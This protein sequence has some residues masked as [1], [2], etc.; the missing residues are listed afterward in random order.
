[1]QESIDDIKKL[2]DLGR[3][4]EAHAK[5]ESLLRISEDLRLKQLY[6]LALSKSGV[7]EE[8]LIF[9]EGVY[10]RFPDDPESAGIMGSICKELFKKNQSNPFA[11]R[12]RDTYLKNFLATQNY[13]T[14]INAASMSAMAGQLGKSREIATQVISLIEGKETDFWALATLGEAHMLTKNKPKALEYFVQ[15]RKEAGKDWGKISSVHNQLWLLNHFLPVPNEVMKL[16]NPP[17]V[18]AFIG[19]MIDHPG[20]KEPRFPAAIEKEVKEEITHAIRSLNVHIGYCSLACGGDI[21]FA[22]AMAEQGGEVNIF[23]PF[24]KTDF[25]EVSVAFAGTTWVDRFQALL[26]RFPVTYMS[27]EHYD[28]LDDIF[29]FQTKIIFGAASLRS[30]TYHEE[31]KLLS[32]LS[33]VDLRKKEGGTRDTIGLWPFPKNHTNINPSIFITSTSTTSPVSEVFVP[34]PKKSVNRPVL[35]LAYIDLLAVAPTEKDKI[36]KGFD[37]FKVEEQDAYLI[38]EP[39]DSAML[40][41]FRTESGVIEYVRFITGAVKTFRNQAPYKISFHAG[42]VYVEAEEATATVKLSSTAVQLVKEMNKYTTS[43]SLFASDR[44]AALLG[45]KGNMFSVNYGGFVEFPAP[46]HKTMVFKIA[47]TQNH[48]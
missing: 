33:D 42:P 28:G 4:A 8:A 13:Y 31:P 6:A 18:V 26:D 40:A 19:H 21:L 14:G 46:D 34:L 27:D 36:V 32:V 23:L 25:V 24:K 17:G 37:E 1:M 29:A 11:I 2:I 43:G 20:R 30:G 16:F 41:A 45:L 12:S 15:A 48:N 47:F 39:D 3:Y 44:F 7:P 22:E 38:M 5:A 9:M 10:F 35:Y